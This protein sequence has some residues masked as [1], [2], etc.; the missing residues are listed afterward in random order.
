MTASGRTAEP[1]TDHSRTVP[2]SPPV[3]MTWPDGLKATDSTGP[4]ADPRTGGPSAAADGLRSWTIPFP[5]P[6]ASI[7]PD[8]ANATALTV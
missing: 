2:S 4:A 3:A 8:G 1:E 7:A 6:A 5:Y